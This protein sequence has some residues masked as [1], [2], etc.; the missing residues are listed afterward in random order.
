[1]TDDPLIATALR[2]QAQNLAS[3]REQTA[4]FRNE[5]PRK[6]FCYVK[7]G[8]PDALVGSSAC[9]FTTWMGEHLGTGWFRR[10]FISSF[11]DERAYV[12]CWGINH[13]WYWGWYYRGAGPYCRLYAFKHQETGA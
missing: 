4:R 11:G 2:V 8:R 9:E 12:R 6:Y 7:E 13:I 10:P 1:M 5:K 3:S